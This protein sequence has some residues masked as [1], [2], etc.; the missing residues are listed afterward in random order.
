MTELI[1][2]RLH[3]DEDVGISSDEGL[4]VFTDPMNLF[5]DELIK[6]V[7]TN[8]QTGGQVKLGMGSFASGDCVLYFGGF[9]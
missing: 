3:Y 6:Q 2:Q 1:T 8:T 7:D 9:A 5:L 4:V